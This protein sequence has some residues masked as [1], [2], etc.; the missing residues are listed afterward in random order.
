MDRDCPICGEYMFTSHKKVVS[1]K[2]GHMIH[3]TCHTEYIKTSYRCPICSKS[4][5]NMESQF[6][7][8]D[9]HLEEQPMPPEYKNTRAIILCN[10]CEAKTSTKYHWGGL[11]CEV[12]LSYNTV[13]LQLLNLPSGPGYGPRRNSSVA[14][15]DRGMDVFPMTTNEGSTRVVLQEQAPIHG[16]G[17]AAQARTIHDARHT[18]VNTTPSQRIVA[19][20]VPT[21]PDTSQETDESEDEADMIQLWGRRSPTAGEQIRDDEEI[22]ED[23]EDDGDSDSTLGDDGDE[24][25]DDEE[26]DIVLLGHR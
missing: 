10:D 22:D 3:D 18:G 15:R 14:P 24:D 5:E 26:D 11:K 13:E 9:N 1:M 17:Q 19:V 4:V 25:E 12:C 6:R 21:L 23:E 16:A 8:L 20:P 2:C 7:R